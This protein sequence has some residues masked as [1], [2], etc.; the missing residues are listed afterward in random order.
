[1]RRPRNRYACWSTRGP[2]NGGGGGCH[3]MEDFYP[4][5]HI[6]LTYAKWLW[7]NPHHVVEALSVSSPILK[8]TSTPP[9]KTSFKVWLP[10]FGHNPIKIK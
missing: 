7:P 8:C 6:Q 3:P 1:M 5:L 10:S 9:K 4:R 2:Q